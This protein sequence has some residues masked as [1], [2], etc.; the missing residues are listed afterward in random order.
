MYAKRVASPAKTCCP[1][2]PSSVKFIAN[3]NILIDIGDLGGINNL[4]WEKHGIR[5]AVYIFQGSMTNKDLGERFNLP[6][7]DLDLLLVSNR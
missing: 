5:N 6:V 2:I 1:T 7:K 3:F 4:I